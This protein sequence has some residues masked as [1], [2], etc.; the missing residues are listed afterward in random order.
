[1]LVK[2]VHSK[3]TLMASADK[4]NFDSAS[5]NHHREVWP[6]TYELF[7][8]MVGQGRLELP[9]PGSSGLRSTNW[10]TAPFG[11]N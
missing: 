6:P 7:Y 2:R 11:G 5:Y 9:T 10:A 3:S 8:L 4:S 1:M